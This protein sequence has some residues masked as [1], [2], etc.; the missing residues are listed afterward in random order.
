MYE[1][2]RRRKKQI[3]S[4]G[5]ALVLIILILGIGRLVKEDRPVPAVFGE[6]QMEGA[7]TGSLRQKAKGISQE[8]PPV[9]E[10]DG[11]RSVREEFP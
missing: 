3:F 1:E 10:A 5:I 6:S 4:Y 7:C 11:I 9:P 2:K 8:S